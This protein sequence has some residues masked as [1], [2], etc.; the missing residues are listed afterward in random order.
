M[1]NSTVLPSQISQSSR[2]GISTVGWVVLTVFGLSA[3]AQEPVQ[4]E[5]S[6]VITD[7]ESIFPEDWT[8]ENLKN[9]KPL[10]LPISQ[11]KLQIPIEQVQ[12]SID[13]SEQTSIVDGPAAVTK[14]AKGNLEF[15]LFSMHEDS[16]QATAPTPQPQDVGKKGAPFSSSRLVPF[17]ARLSYPY[18][19]VGKLYFQKSNARWTCSGAVVG[20]RL[21]LTAGHCVHRG[22]G[23]DDGF[24]K[25]FLFVPAH[26]AGN[27]PFGAWSWSWIVTTGSWNNSNGNVPN[28]GDI[29][30][31]EFEDKK[32]DGELR[33]LGNQLGGWFGY[34]TNNLKN[35]HTKKIGYPGN[36]DNGQIM[37]QVD[38]EDFGSGRNGTRLYGSDMRDGSSGGPWVMNFGDNGRDESSGL[39]PWRPNRIV[40]VTS[41]GF[42]ST[43]Q[44]VQG[45]SILG[46]EFLKIYDM[47][48][49][50]RKGNC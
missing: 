36:F 6:S 43:A 17:D 33:K 8:S 24:Y 13:A 5:N 41:Y 3:Y 21:V 37:R 44:K 25:G 7:S 46:K 19:L 39:E 34:R 11:A 49:K 26:N 29:A 10:E 14:E 18:K 15:Q 2:F 23:D 32:V 35:N 22:S 20:P 50:G 38:S 31:I 9:A 48:C 30:I 42:E 28:R 40:G 12:E 27:A 1:R 4:L 47:A 45:S 16:M